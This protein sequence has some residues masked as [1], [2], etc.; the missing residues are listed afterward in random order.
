MRVDKRPRNKLLTN[1]NNGSSLTFAGQ[2][3]P[4]LRGQFASCWTDVD[5]GQLTGADGLLIKVRIS[6]LQF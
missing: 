5:A 3:A 2:L 4:S 6:L 1:Q